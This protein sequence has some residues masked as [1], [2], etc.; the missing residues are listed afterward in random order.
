MSSGPQVTTVWPGTGD[1]SIEN[2]GSRVGVDVGAVKESEASCAYPPRAA[3][4]R[5]NRE[6]LRSMSKRMKGRLNRQRLKRLAVPT[7]CISVGHKGDSA[8]V[9][10]TEG[11]PS[12]T[13]L[14]SVLMRVDPVDLWA[15]ASCR[16]RSMWDT[17]SQ[18]AQSASSNGEDGKNKSSCITTRN[19]ILAL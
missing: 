15:L 4:P 9:Y 3:N 7:L 11:T 6:R 17:A 19:Y 8:S 10:R 5:H 14:V 1:I 12:G 18:E 16:A 2:P 13:G